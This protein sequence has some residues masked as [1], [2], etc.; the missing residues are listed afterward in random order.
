[1]RNECSSSLKQK[2]IFVK[3]YSKPKSFV[4]WAFF[5]Q[6]DF[7]NEIYVK[8]RSTGKM[9]KADIKFNEKNA[10]INLREDEFGISPGQACVF[11]RKDSNGDK[12]LGGGWIDK[13]F[14]RNLST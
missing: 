1:M 3:E 11:Y 2:K 14:N 8:V 10:E 9:I 4:I 7:E 13:T 5:T 12:V 6:K